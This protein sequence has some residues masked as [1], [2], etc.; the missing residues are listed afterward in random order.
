MSIVRSSLHSQQGSLEGTKTG[1]E[2][3][4]GK[5]S[6]TRRR[7]IHLLR[8]PALKVSMMDDSIGN[9]PAKRRPAVGNIFYGER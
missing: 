1:E 5:S 8:D 3:Q 6:H 2:Q 7:V 4:E 9:Q